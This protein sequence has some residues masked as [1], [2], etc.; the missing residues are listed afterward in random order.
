MVDDRIDGDGRLACLTVAD[1]Q[2]TLASSDGYHGVDGLDARLKGSVHAFSRDD[3]ACHTLYFAVFVGLD[4]A[5][6]VNGLSQR[7]HHASR[8]SIPYRNLYHTSGR[9]DRIAFIDVPGAAQEHHAYVIFFQIQH[10][11][12]HFAGEFQQLALHGVFQPMHARDAVRHLDDGTH[13]GHIQ[14]G[15]IPLDLILDN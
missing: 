4:R 11:A 12:V 9:L 6:A 10:H 8:H 7:I 13:I 14:R 1:D 2:L 15:R 5:F 3:S